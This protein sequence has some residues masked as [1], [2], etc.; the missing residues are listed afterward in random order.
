MAAELM[1]TMGSAY[2]GIGEYR[3]AE[4]LA[5]AAL[6]LNRARGP[7]GREAAAVSLLLLGD[8][9]FEC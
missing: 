4:E 7:V 3:R 1:N 8:V 2:F 5:E 9:A 6:A